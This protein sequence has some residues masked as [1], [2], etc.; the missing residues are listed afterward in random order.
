VREKWMRRAMIENASAAMDLARNSKKPVL[1]TLEGITMLFQGMERGVVKNMPE[2]INRVM[3][4]VIDTINEMHEA[5]PGAKRG[6]STGIKALDILLGG[7]LK[8]GK[9][10]LLGGRPGMG[11]SA[12]ALGWCV[13]AAV[14]EDEISLYLSQEMPELEVGQ[15]A[16]AHEAGVSYTRIQSGALQDIEWGRLTE[17]TEKLSKSALHVLEQSGLTKEDISIKVRSV[18]GVKLIVLDYVQLCAGAEEGD[19]TRNAVLEK[20]SRFLKQLAM[21]LDAAVVVLSALNRVVE[22]RRN[23]RALMRDFKDCGALEADAD[24]ILSLFE[25]RPRDSAGTRLMGI[26]VLKQRAGPTGAVSAT[27]HGDYM[28]FTD[29]EYE[30]EELLKKVRGGASKGSDM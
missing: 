1:D 20:I 11:K 14:D 13:D 8:G 28:Q 2:Q 17:G 12:L 9:V 18:K 30:L 6:I 26:D 15:R 5:G 10:Y 7:G 24:V 16:L 25:A 27:F 23:G 19:D 22:D 29:C 21:V 4:K 3:C